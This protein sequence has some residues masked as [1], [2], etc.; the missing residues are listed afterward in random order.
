MK[1]RK[2]IS[3]EEEQGHN[4]KEALRKN[5]KGDPEDGQEDHE[6]ATRTPV[7]HGGHVHTGR[8]GGDRR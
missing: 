2:Q 1:S 5:D 8:D 6:I 4:L 7:S 3:K